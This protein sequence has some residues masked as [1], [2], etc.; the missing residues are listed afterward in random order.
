M[1]YKTLASCSLFPS[2][3]PFAA[4]D[5]MWWC[6]MVSAQDGGR[7]PA[8]CA[9]CEMWDGS[10]SQ[11]Y[12]TSH[13]PGS[14]YRWEEGGRRTQWLPQG[15]TRNWAMAGLETQP[16]CPRSS[17]DGPKRC[18]HALLW[19]LRGPEGRITA[20][21]TTWVWFRSPSLG[22]LWGISLCSGTSPGMDR[23]RGN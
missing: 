13:Q 11:H 2:P 14:P 8:S 12:P 18:F 15:H 10:S 20:P 5:Q 1:L 7:Y 19:L 23:E 3:V 4:R 17:P 16:R 21:A 22:G 6:G 9:L